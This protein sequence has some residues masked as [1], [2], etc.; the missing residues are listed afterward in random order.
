[1]MYWHLIL[2]E[3]SMQLVLSLQHNL[4]QKKEKKVLNLKDI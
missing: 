3:Q 1:M 4:K 2:H